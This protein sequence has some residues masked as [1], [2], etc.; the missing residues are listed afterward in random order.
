MTDA[1]ISAFI[2]LVSV[3]VFV[4]SL[5]WP[6]PVDGSEIGLFHALMIYASAAAAVLAGAATLIL[7][8]SGR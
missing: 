7:W 1:N 8:L 5:L 2:A 4:L 3:L 6:E